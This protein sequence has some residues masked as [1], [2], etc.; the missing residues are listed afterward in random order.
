MRAVH[1]A[2]AYIV[3]AYGLWCAVRRHCTSRTQAVACRLAR[4]RAPAA[5]HRLIYSTTV[6][7]PLERGGTGKIIG[8]VRNGVCGGLRWSLC[9][10]RLEVRRSGYVAWRGRSRSNTRY[11]V[12]LLVA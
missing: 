12:W 7:I 3:L 8:I 1:V 11:R 2:S 10:T 5:L 4:W 6:R 9:M